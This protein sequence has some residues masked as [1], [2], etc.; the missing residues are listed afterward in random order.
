MSIVGD[1]IFGNVVNIAHRVMEKTEPDCI[2][3]TQNLYQSAKDK[4]KGNSLCP[5]MY[6]NISQPVEVYNVLIEEK[7]GDWVKACRLI[8]AK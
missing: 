7:D 6:K 1:D 5:R 4:V 8:L 3:I 2:T